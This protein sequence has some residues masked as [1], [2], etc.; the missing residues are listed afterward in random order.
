MVAEDGVEFFAGAQQVLPGGARQRQ[1]VPFESFFRRHATFEDAA[2]GR[3]EIERSFTAQRAEFARWGED[4]EFTH[5]DRMRPP[6]FGGLGGGR[7]VIEKEG[8]MEGRKMGTVHVGTVP[9]FETTRLTLV[10]FNHG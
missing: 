8:K 7:E 3:R 4:F 9:I 5:A 6:A 2:D 1:G 10:R